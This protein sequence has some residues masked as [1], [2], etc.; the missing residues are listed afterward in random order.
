[1]ILTFIY[2]YAVYISMLY[3]GEEVIYIVEFHYLINELNEQ[4]APDVAS[5]T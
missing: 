4:D 2:G 3:K 1:M 5:S